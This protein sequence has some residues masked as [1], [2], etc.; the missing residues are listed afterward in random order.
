MVQLLAEARPVDD[1]AL[2]AALADQFDSVVGFDLEDQPAALHPDQ[3]HPRRD[4]EANGSGGAVAD[5]DMGADGLFG[6]PVEMG[7]DRLDAGP[8]Q[9]LTAPPAR[10]TRSEGAF[11]DL[12]RTIGSGGCTGRALPPT[13]TRAERR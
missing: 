8:F 9:L 10:S 1:V 12:P 11:Q 3:F 2:V 6:R 4:L 13:M 7:V 5:V